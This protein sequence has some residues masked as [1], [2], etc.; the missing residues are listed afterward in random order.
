MWDKKPSN[1]IRNPVLFVTIKKDTNSQPS[2][3][4][5]SRS[6]H[7]PPIE[8]PLRWGVATNNLVLSFA[9]PETPTSR[10]HYDVYSSQGWYAG[11]LCTCQRSSRHDCERAEG[12][13]ESIV[14]IAQIVPLSLSCKGSVQQ[15]N[16]K[17]TVLVI[18]CCMCT[19]CANYFL[20]M[21]EGMKRNT[22]S[23][24]VRSP[25]LSPT[26]QNVLQVILIFFWKT[27]WRAANDIS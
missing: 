12:K 24:D 19:Q 11:F 2:L 17:N 4:Q 3:W 16:R 10:F 5:L 6:A 26:A 9:W 25:T 20:P 21:H 7:P 23:K 27:I 8:N 13:S 14:D 18:V 1:P 22:C 15:L